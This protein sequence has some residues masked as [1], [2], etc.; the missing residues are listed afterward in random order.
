MICQTKLGPWSLAPP[1]AA[2]SYKSKF[3]VMAAASVAQ[4]KV[5]DRRSYIACFSSAG[6]LKN[7]WRQLL[8]I[9][10]SAATNSWFLS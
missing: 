1:R 5:A 8:S 9:R 6:G 2:L 3:V 10:L 4:S 7:G